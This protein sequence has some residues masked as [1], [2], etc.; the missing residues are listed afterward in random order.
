LKGAFAKD[1]KRKR[2]VGA[3]SGVPI[4]K[5]P[6]HLNETERACWNELVKL[7]PAGVLQRENATL[8]ELTARL[9]AETRL[10]DDARQPV[11]MKI[12]TARLVLLKECL[13]QMGLTPAAR[14]KVYAEPQEDPNKKADPLDE[15]G[16]SAPR[17]SRSVH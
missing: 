8:L 6:V 3:K 9:F 17:S 16:K 4:G 1:P 2:A 13:V 5:P 11:F 10:L 14:S 15:F 12:S 7:A